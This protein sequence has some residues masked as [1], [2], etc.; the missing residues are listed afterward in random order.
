MNA[1]DSYDK[2]LKKIDKHG[3]ALDGGKFLLYILYE[4]DPGGAMAYFFDARCKKR[5]LF[6]STFY[7]LLDEG[8]AVRVDPD[9]F[10]K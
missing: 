7:R 5:R 6:T 1:Q 8:K 2:D 4:G 10:E 9:E 3:A